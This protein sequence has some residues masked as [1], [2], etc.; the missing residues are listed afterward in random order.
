MQ[1]GDTL[2]YIIK[3]FFSLSQTKLCLPTKQTSRL[4]LTKKGNKYTVFVWLNRAVIPQISA[5][6]W[7]KYAW[8]T[9]YEILL[10]LYQVQVHVFWVEILI[11]ISANTVST[12]TFPCY[13]WLI[14]PVHTQGSLRHPSPSLNKWKESFCPFHTNDP[15]YAAG[16][17]LCPASPQL[18]EPQK[19]SQSS[20]L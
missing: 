18:P 5:A 16:K 3:P 6:K 4:L 1:W 17:T 10:T 19:W 2:T 14:S 8:L 7:F 20:F 15:G 9:R 13:L 11:P 12:T